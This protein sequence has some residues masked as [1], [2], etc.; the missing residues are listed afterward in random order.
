MDRQLPRFELPID[1]ELL[2]NIAKDAAYV[3][4]GFGVLSFQRAQVRRQELAKAA[5]VRFGAA[6][7]RLASVEA[8]VEHAIEQVADQLP[9]PTGEFIGQLHRTAKAARTQIRSRLRAA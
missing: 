3:A 2:L 1:G 4:V 7:R 5:E 6:E 8:K 9:G